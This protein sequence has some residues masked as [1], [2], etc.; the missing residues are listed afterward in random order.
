M[1][2]ITQLQ[3]PGKT[4]YHSDSCLD[5]YVHFFIKKVLLTEKSGHNPRAK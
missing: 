4:F 1:Y 5:K 3:S 2:I